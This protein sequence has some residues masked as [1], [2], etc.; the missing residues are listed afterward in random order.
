MALEDFAGKP[1]S[2]ADGDELPVTEGGSSMAAKRRAVQRMFSAAK[3]GDWKGAAEAFKDAFEACEAY[4][5]DEAED[6]EDEAS[7]TYEG[8]DEEA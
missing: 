3:K 7:T 5:D 4:E 6:D 1:E 8:E 2:D